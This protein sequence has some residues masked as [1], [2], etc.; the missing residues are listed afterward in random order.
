MF[1]K[2]N[3]LSAVNIRSKHVLFIGPLF[4]KF[5]CIFFGV[6]Y[7]VFLKFFS[8]F[9]T[10][11]GEEDNCLSVD[12]H[13]SS[14]DCHVL[15]QESSAMPPAASGTVIQRF[16]IVPVDDL[17]AGRQ[18]NVSDHESSCSRAA[19]AGG[20]EAVVCS[21]EHQN[22]RPILKKRGNGAQV[23]TGES[24]TDITAVDSVRVLVYILHT[25]C[26]YF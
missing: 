7:S 6:D 21:V 4:H 20:H 14:G 18:E 10:P 2:I 19:A 1:C 11:S 5:L 17:P 13:P 9:S 23:N 15:H 25:Y 26:T 16:T 8:N 24:Q 22:L 12:A 3:F